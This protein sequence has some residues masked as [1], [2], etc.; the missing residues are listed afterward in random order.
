MDHASG[1]VSVGPA[2]DC[3]S[4]VAIPR[5]KHV[6]WNQILQLSSVVRYLF[7]GTMRVEFLDL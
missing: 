1:V 7:S 6:G 5:V 4:E 3:V 2:V